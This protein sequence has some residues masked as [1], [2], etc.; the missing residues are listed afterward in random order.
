VIDRAHAPPPPP[1]TR[2]FAFP[3]VRLLEGQFVWLRRVR[4]LHGVG[5]CCE[6]GVRLRGE[7]IHKFSVF[8]VLFHMNC[9]RLPGSGRFVLTRYLPRVLF[10]SKLDRVIVRL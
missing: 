1:R 6:L 10:L 9:V 3:Q 2:L 5:W 7:H 8:N 4:R